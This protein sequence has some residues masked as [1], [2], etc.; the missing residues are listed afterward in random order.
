MTTLADK[1]ILSSADNRP[2]MLEKDMYDSWKSIMELYMMNRQ[3][4]RMILESVENGPLIW[5]LIKENGVTRPKKYSDLSATKAIQDDCDIKATNIILQGLPPKVFALVSNHKVAKELWE[6]I[7]LLMQGTSLTKQERELNT[8]FLN[9]LPPE[10]SK[11]VTNVKLVQDLHTTNIDQLHAY[12]GQH[13][14]HANKVRLM[15]ERN[16]YPLALVSPRHES[17]YQSQQYSNNQSSKPL[18]ITYPSNDYQSS[19]HHNVYSPSSSIPQL[20]YAPSVNQQPEFSQPESGLIVLVFQRGNDP[21]DAINHVISFLTAVVTSR[22]PTTNN[23]LRNSSNPRQQATIN[24]G[25]VNGQILHEEELAFLAD[26]R[27]TKDAYDSNC[28]EFNTT[29]VSLMANLSHY[30]SD[31]LAEVRNPNNMDNNMIN[32]GVQ[33][34]PSSEQSNVVNCSETE[35]TSDSNISPYSK[36]QQLEPKLYDGNVIKNTSAIVIP[37]YEET[38]MLAEESRL[39]MLLKQK[40]PMMLEKKVN[41]TPVDY[42]VLNQLSQDF[43][44]RFVPQTELSAEQAFWSQNSMNSPKP[45][46]SSR[47]TKVE[48][49]KELPKVSMVNTSLKKLKH[50]LAGFDVVVKERTT[51]TAITEGSWGFEHTKACFR[52]EIIPF[53]KALKDLFNTFDQYLIDELSEVQNVFHQMEQ[54]VEQH[55][56]ESK[57]FEVKMNQ[58]LNENER[59]LEQ[60]INKDIVN[61]IMNSSVDNAS[62]NVHECEKCL[63]LETELLNKK[64]FVEKEIYDK[65][66]KSFTTLEKHCISLEVDTQ[67]NQEIFQRDNSVSNQ[68]APSFDQLFELNELKAQ[69]Q[70]KDTVIKK[71]KERIKSLSGKMNEDK[72]KKDLEEIETINIELDHR[73]SKLIAENEHLKQTYKQLYDSIK[74][75]RIRS[76]EQCDDLINQV[77]LKS[78]EISDLNAS[79]QEKVLVITTLKDDLRK[80]KGKALVDNDVTK[81]PSD[82]EVLKIDVEPI[83]PKLLNKKTDHSAYIKHTQEEATVLRDLVEHVKSKYPL[84]Q[85]LESAC[86]YAK[87]IQ[88]LL[89]NI[90]KTCPSINNADG[91][92]VVVTPKNKDKRVRFTKPITSSRNTNTKTSSSSN[93]VSNKP[94]LSS[95]GVKPSTSASGSQPS[96]NTKKDKIQQTPSSTQKN[97]VEAYPR[98]FKPNLKNKDCVVE[99]KGTAH[100]QHSKLNANFEL[101][102]VKCNGCMLSDNHD[103]CVLD[104]INNVNARTKS[105][106]VK[107]HSKRKVWKPTRKVFTNIG[108]IW[109]PTG[110]TFTIVGNACPLTRITTTT[111]VPLRKPTALDNETSKPVITLVYSRKPKKSK[112]NVPVSKSKVLKSVLANKKEAI[113]SWGSIVSDVPSSSLDEFMSSKLFPVK[114]GNDH[115]AKILG[116]G[117]YQIRNVTISRVY[118][119][120]G[121]GHNLFSVGQFCDSNLEV[122]FRQHTCFIRN[123]ASVD[124]LTGSQGKNL[125]TLSLRDM[126]ASSPICLLSKA[127]KT[128]SW[129]WHRRLSHLNFGAINHLARHGLVRGLPKLNFEKDHLC[130]ACAIG[131]SKKKPHKPKSEDTNQEKLYLLHMDLCGPMCVAS[132]NGKKYILVIVDDYSRFTWVK[133]LR[134]K[135]E[136]P[137]FIIKFLKMIQVRLKVPVRRIRTDNGTEFINQTLREYYEKVG[138]SHETSV[139]CSPQQNG[140]VERHNRTLIEAARTMLIYAKALLFLWAEAVATACYTQN[141]SIVRLRY[142]KTQ[143]ELL[144]DKLSDLS[145]FHVF[146]ALCYPTNDSENL[147]NLQPKADIDFDELTVMASEHSS[148]GP[149]LHEMTPK[150]II[151]G[152]VPNPPP[153]TPFVPPLRTDWD[154]LFQPFAPVPIISTGS[155]SSTT[156]D[157]DAPSPTS[158][159]SDV[160]PT[161]MKSAAPYSEH[162]EAMQEELNEFEHLEVW[163]LVPRPDKVMVIVK[164]RESILRNPLLQWL[165][166]MLFEFSSQVYVSQPDGFMDQENPNHVYKLKKALYGLKQAH[167]AWYDLLSKFLLS[168]EF[169]KGTVD[170]TLFIRRQGNDLLQY[171]KDS[172]IALTAYADADHAGCQDTRRSTSG[173]MQFLGDRLVSW[174]SKRHKSTAISSTEAEYIAMSGCC[175]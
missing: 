27:I 93:L 70:E 86:R 68:S 121:L 114:F 80:L 67:L 104:F 162:I 95:T 11:F 53:V 24:D 146:G 157:Q 134:S 29:K 141:R 18:S 158:S 160:I 124:L 161:V 169:S 120:E 102:C 145:F 84:D 56:L 109:R 63:K 88:E 25:R 6:T 28:D 131:K 9:T 8:K 129:L 48:V 155:P 140:I 105:K 69:S 55:R 171:P 65:L 22:Y 10:W 62:V 126:M 91:K 40:D 58:V 77:N 49:P 23:Q 16:S 97:K 52:D 115:V 19:V 87:R 50:H 172:S 175:A 36:A 17:S 45:T 110:R 148:S 127:S 147:G 83:T 3:H 108:Y 143:Y 30:G 7:Q 31:A 43:E 89:T 35:I 165:N 138:I 41:T 133:C 26:L 159:S 15:H 135:D 13:E 85:S 137:D 116:Y 60:V 57:T 156:V 79:L 150:I 94:V 136:A 163:E 47:P 74:P 107:K 103:L 76:K 167:C 44:T 113:K 122:S 33:V 39:K 164:K 81:H 78:V 106:S 72:I 59:L 42:A 101:K 64:D 12:L 92:L 96:G 174:S 99:P 112:T 118:Y 153:S 125:Y 71:L 37:D 142:D 119:V 2:P 5:P 168:Q 152:L 90:S 20:E 54:A 21:I 132:V 98:K 100:V 173:S 1:V 166:L 139:A 73:V 128:K 51:A 14:F 46:L 75:A 170:P 4:G 32:Q 38:L 111:E 66:F 151:S 149:A 144:H 61:I 154:I 82:S 130:S 34:M 117:D 123:L